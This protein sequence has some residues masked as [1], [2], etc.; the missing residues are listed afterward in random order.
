MDGR[1]VLRVDI[2]LYTGIILWASFYRFHIHHISF[3]LTNIIDRSSYASVYNAKHREL[4]AGAFRLA[5]LLP[6]DKDEPRD[7]S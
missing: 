1:T 2:G 5:P 3:W 4:Y 7:P 6:H